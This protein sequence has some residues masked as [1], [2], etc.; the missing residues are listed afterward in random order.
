MRRRDCITGIASSAIA[1]PLAAQAQRQIKPVVGFLSVGSKETDNFRL[2]AFQR[3]LAEAGFV[4][5]QNVITE[6]RWAENQN[7]NLPA[8]AAD[9][10][11]R[12][13]AAIA[14]IGGVAPALAAKAATASVPI[15]FVIAIDP[16]E[17][18]LVASLNRPGGNITGITFL[19]GLLGAKQFELLHNTI[20]NADVMG[21]LVN[22]TNPTTAFVVKDVQEAAERLGQKLLIVN[23]STENDFETAFATFSDHYIKALLVVTDPFFH[24]RPSQL[25]GL[26]ARYAIPTLYGLRGFVLAGGLMSY[27]TSLTDGYRLQ[28]IYIGK[29][30][31]GEKPADL[32]VIQSTKF[33]FV[34]N[35]KTAKTLGLDV[36]MTIQ[37]TA[38]EVVE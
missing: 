19:V 27:G 22:P 33:E 6:Y 4:D 32:P 34:L 21:L 30:L 11:H 3:G 10:V 1:W 28:G 20:P 23:A 35:L 31:K 18:G 29:I 26:A 12:G 16:V 37:M 9:L 13:V 14:T 5:G 17:I 8:L 38:D 7:D 36:P 25:A 24:S 15:V 2:V